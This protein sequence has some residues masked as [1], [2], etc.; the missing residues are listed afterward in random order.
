M[1]GLKCVML[2]KTSSETHHNCNSFYLEE[3]F[4]SLWVVAVALS[5]DSLHFLDL[6][7]LAGSLDVLKVNIGL[8]TEIHNR[9]KE[10]K[11]T[12]DQ[13]IRGEQQKRLAHSPMN[14]SVH[15]SGFNPNLHAEP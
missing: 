5:T 1:K 8:L 7:C 15:F 13:D 6:T 3:V 4:D 9:S 14:K 2:W 12:F 11:Q 10:V